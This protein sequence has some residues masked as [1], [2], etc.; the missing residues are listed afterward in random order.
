VLTG[1]LDN[2]RISECAH[3]LDPRRH[4][5][6]TVGYRALTKPVSWWG[7]HGYLKERIARV[8]E[9]ALSINNIDFDIST[10]TKDAKEGQSWLAFMGDCKYTLGVE[11]GT[12]ILDCSGNVKVATEAY[13]L[14]HPNAK[15]E[16]I[17]AACFPNFDGKFEGY[18]I[19]PRHLE[20]CLTG[21]C[22]IL[23]EG[24]YNGILKPNIHYIPVAKDF[25]NIEQVI[26][27]IKNDNLRVEIINNAYRDIVKSGKYNMSIFS[28]TVIGDLSIYSPHNFER[29]EK[30]KFKILYWILNMLD[31]FDRYISI[32]KNIVEKFLIKPSSL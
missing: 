12:S 26:E 10:E 9:R 5:N 20:A 13:I 17:E 11:S 30:F 2:K 19:A 7:R 22:Q 24:F 14:D 21:T 32:I 29:L 8:F 3:F 31:L 15:F 4:R 6:T 18:M 27:N 16:D 23:T 25:S 1:Y 28:S